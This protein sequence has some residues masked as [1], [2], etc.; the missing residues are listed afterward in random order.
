MAA[1]VVRQHTVRLPAA[2]FDRIQVRALAAR[3]SINQEIA[4][5]LEAS[6]GYQEEADLAAATAP[7]S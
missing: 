6:V 7:Q 5:M 1:A 4:L 2:L 3:H